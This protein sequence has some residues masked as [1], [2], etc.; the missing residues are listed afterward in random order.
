MTQPKPKWNKKCN[1]LVCDS[2]MRDG[3]IFCPPCYKSLPLRLR[4]PL[5]SQDLITLGRAI[6][7]AKQWL[8]DKHNAIPVVQDEGP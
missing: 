8:E 3:D 2:W 5:W 1:S 4:Q 7:E 6:K